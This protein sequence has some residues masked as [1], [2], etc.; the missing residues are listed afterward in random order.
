MDLS[1]EPLSSSSFSA[2]SLFH[3][4]KRCLEALSQEEPKRLCESIEERETQPDEFKEGMNQTNNQDI[5]APDPSGSLSHARHS[6]WVM[7]C[8]FCRL[9]EMFKL[10]QCSRGLSHVF[11]DPLAWIHINVDMKLIFDRLPS[12]QGRIES[13][14]KRIPS[15]KTLSLTKKTDADRPYQEMLAS[16]WR[17]MSEAHGP[18]VTSLDIIESPLLPSVRRSLGT[19][20][21]N[22]RRLDCS[23]A[24]AFD[25]VSLSISLPQLQ[26]L[27]TLQINVD[28]PSSSRPRYSACRFV[29]RSTR[30]F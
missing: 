7:A 9:P 12:E 28:E 6:G 15:C 20:F 2:S 14:L 21:S 23:C 19:A 17:Q 4:Q 11:D 1:L 5:Q 27:E 10:R 25:M 22:L 26:R 13:I 30:F 24:T 18:H 16:V 29:P 8:H 3:G